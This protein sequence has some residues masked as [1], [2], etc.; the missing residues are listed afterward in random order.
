M[1]ADESPE[2]SAHELVAT[3]LSTVEAGALAVVA[4]EPD[5]YDRLLPRPGRTLKEAAEQA[6]HGLGE[7]LVIAHRRRSPTDTRQRL[8]RHLGEQA[9]SLADMTVAAEDDMDTLIAIRD[10]VFVIR[11]TLATLGVPHATS[12]NDVWNVEIASHRTKSR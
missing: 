8:L 1:L 4:Q 5:L 3:T 6:L 10:Q 11:E 7:Q 9:S 12:G 2:A